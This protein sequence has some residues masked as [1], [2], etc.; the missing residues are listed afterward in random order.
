MVAPFNFAR[1]PAVFFGAG[2]SNTLHS[3]LM[4]FG[5]TVLI[6]T[7]QAS[8][9]KTGRLD[10]LLSS[11]KDNEIKHYIF[12]I[13]GEP[14]PEIVD[15]AVSEFKSKDI[16]AIVGIG[17]GSVID[18]AKAISAMLPLGVGV[19]N[20]LEGVGGGVTHTGVKVPFIAVPTTSGTGS[21]TTKN[22]V[23]SRIGPDGFKKSLRHDN[24]VPD[25][26]LI[27]PALTLS[28][29]QDVTAACAMDAFTQLM[30]SYVSVKASP[31]TDSLAIGALRLAMEN[32]EAACTTG[33]GDIRARSAMSYAA[34]I[35]GITL[36]NAGLGVVHGLASTVGGCFDIPHGVL[37]GTV[38]GAATRANITALRR[39]GTAAALQK[40]ADIGSLITG[41]KDL[42]PA[43]EAL[44]EKIDYWTETLKLQRLGKYG[45]KQGH[46]DRLASNAS[47]KESPVKLTKEEIIAI[48]L[49]RL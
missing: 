17:G 3:H 49:D 42:N 11:L 21:E 20:Y 13:T 27:D 31:M 24:F 22:A 5:R 6:V 43:L 14:S 26:A 34:A 9:K 12:Q 23:L 45:I 46:L 44:I 36:A 25:V 40:Y 16:N 33:A 15:A 47:N 41:E 35:S 32:L 19:F 2:V 1:T 38:A 48:L 18:G 7:G 8:L 29:P 39:D 30:E 37:C 10:K 4:P 28:S